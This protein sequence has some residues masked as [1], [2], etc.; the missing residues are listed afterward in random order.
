MSSP[1]IRVDNFIIRSERSNTGEDLGVRTECRCSSFVE[2]VSPS[3]LFALILEGDILHARQELQEAT[4]FSDPRALTVR[5]TVLHLFPGITVSQ[6]A[7]LFHRQVAR[8]NNISLLFH[9]ARHQYDHATQPSLPV[10]NQP[11][12]R[13]A[14]MS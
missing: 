12:L 10:T 13:L 3:L 5:F 11:L 6:P 8:Y 1:S 7:D 2:S 14:L 4:P 9:C